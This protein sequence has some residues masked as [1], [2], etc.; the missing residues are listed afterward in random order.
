MTGSWKPWSIAFQCIFSS[1]VRTTHDGRS[2]AP[3]QCTGCSGSP[4]FVS[5]ATYRASPRIAASLDVDERPVV[6]RVI[7]RHM[8]Y[9]P[10]LEKA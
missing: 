9:A 3:D 7:A 4:I 6:L 8:K 5:I 10:A 2:E 1:A